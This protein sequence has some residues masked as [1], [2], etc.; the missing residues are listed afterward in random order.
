MHLIASKTNYSE[1]PK[2]EYMRDL[3]SGCKCGSTSSGTRREDGK[4]V[5]HFD[6]MQLGLA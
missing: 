2:T 3:C 5:G 6:K 4:N 1:T